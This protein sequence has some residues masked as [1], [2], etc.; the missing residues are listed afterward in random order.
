M[1]L[2]LTSNGRWKNTVVVLWIFLDEDV[3]V[4]DEN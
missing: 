3:L 2:Y 1:V 4:S